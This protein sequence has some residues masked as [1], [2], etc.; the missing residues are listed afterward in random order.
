MLKNK[1]V[2]SRGFTIVELLIVIVVIAILAGISIATY[3]GIQE[4]AHSTAI[5]NGIKST[6]KALRL[7]GT[8]KGINSWW[9][10]NSSDLAGVGNSRIESII[11][12][13][14]EFKAYLQQVQPVRGVNSNEWFYD[15]DGDVMATGCTTASNGVGLYIYDLAANSSSINPSILQKVD[16]TMDDGNLNCGKLRSYGNNGLRYILSYD[17]SF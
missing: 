1:A 12:T 5:I 14:P 7:Y 2:N 15:N 9:I 10:D 4:R 16:D 3:S 17:G 8:Q 13:Q 6:E 11:A